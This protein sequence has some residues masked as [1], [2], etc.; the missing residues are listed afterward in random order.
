MFGLKKVMGS[1]EQ[2]LCMSIQLFTRHPPSIFG[3]YHSNSRFSTLFSSS[4]SES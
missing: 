4:T 1:C 3:S 2:T